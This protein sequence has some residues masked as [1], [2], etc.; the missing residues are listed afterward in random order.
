MAKKQKKSSAK[1]PLIYPEQT[2][3]QAFTAILLQQ[4][5]QLQLW[6][7]K[8]RDWQDIEGV[9]QMRVA[10]RRMRS[11]LRTFRPALPRELSDPWSDEMRWC[12]SQ[13][14]PARDLD[15]FIDEGLNVVTDQLPLPG[16]SKLE[17]IAWQ[18]REQAYQTVNAMLDSERYLD[19]KQNFQHWLSDQPWRQSDTLED[20]QQQRLQSNIAPFACKRLNKLQRQVL[21]QGQDIDQD[22]APVMHELRIE[23]KKLRYAAEF[24]RPLFKGMDQFIRS[25]KVLQELLGTMNDV[26]VMK[27]LLQDL[28]KNRRDKELFQ[29][30]GGLIGWRAHEYYRLKD[31]FPQRWSEFT[32][33]KLPWQDKALINKAA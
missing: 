32:H 9:H 11:L 27:V 16:E 14:G 21:E 6:E 1:K 18:R 15:V 30:A 22:S 31:S 25:L 17:T 5:Q 20:K 7:D 3:N 19:F 13:L 8:A 12:A 28:L 4:L 33:C 29:Y 23:C 2:V 26:E 24:F 10:L